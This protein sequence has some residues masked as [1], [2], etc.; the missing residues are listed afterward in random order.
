MNTNDFTKENPLK[1]AVGSFISSY[2]QR[3]TSI[4]FSQWLA[5]QLRQ[6][7]PGMSQ[8]A[9]EKLAGEIIEAVAEHDKK[10]HDLNLAI[11]EGKSKKEWL[12][13]QLS[14][15]YSGMPLDEAGEKLQRIETEFA[16]FNLQ[17]ME[18]G[19]RVQ[20][21]EADR[22][23]AWD[24]YSIKSTVY[25]IGDQTILMGQAAVAS[26][27]NGTA[28]SSGGTDNV[29]KKLQAALKAVPQEVK[30]VIAGAVRSAIENG[31]MVMLPLSTP[32][33]AICD[34]DGMTVDG[35]AALLDAVNGEINMMEALERIGRA[36][37]AVGCCAGR[38]VLEDYVLAVPYVGPVLVDLLGGL[39][40]HMESPQFRENMY[41][42]IHDAAIATWQGVKESETVKV[43]QETKESVLNRVLHSL[44]GRKAYGENKIC[45]ENAR[46]CRG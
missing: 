45:V 33:E 36:G 8:E 37:I 27:L 12:A 32:T 19:S 35:A 31:L 21:T 28:N 34:M 41:A 44:Q 14:E 24:K 25:G 13:D 46:W 40:D 7:A 15:A 1:K 18:G 17:V 10:L 16:A 42:L 30:A 39:F 9:S 5:D 26:A 20:S 6:E 4:E 11:E 38:Y 29:R 22:T 23:V 43:L 2:A 3:D